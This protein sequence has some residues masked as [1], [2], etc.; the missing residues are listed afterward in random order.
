MLNFPAT[1]ARLTMPS[2]KKPLALALLLPV[3]AAPATAANHAKHAAQ[4]V[5]ESLPAVTIFIDATLGMRKDSAAKALTDAHAAYE[6]HG[7]AVID[8]ETY[9]ENGDLQGLFV[10][11][12]STLQ[13][14]R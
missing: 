10:T 4:A 14:G 12:R 7:Y 1:P 3:L 5:R 11:Y 6:A 13:P 2:L 9:T 8:V